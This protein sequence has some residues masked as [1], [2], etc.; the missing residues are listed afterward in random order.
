MTWTGTKMKRA[1]LLWN[2]LGSSVA[3]AEMLSQEWD[4]LITPDALRR[5]LSRK[6][7]TEVAPFEQSAE[8]KKQRIRP[9]QRDP[10][11]QLLFLAG[12]VH[13]PEHSRA[14]WGAIHQWLEDEQPDE[15]HLVGDVGEYSS[16][17]RHGGNW[18]LMFEDEC[19]QV[20][21]FINDLKKICPEAT[22]LYYEGNHETRY[23]RFIDENA[24]ALSGTHSIPK[25]CKLEE[26]GVEWVPENKQPVRRGD[27]KI[28]HGHQESRHGGELPK[29][30]AMKMAEVYG[31][32]GASVVYFHTHKS[33]KFSAP[34]HGG[35]AE[36]LAIGC[37][38]NLSPK[39]MHGKE[40]GW[41]HQFCAAYVSPN[42]HVDTYPVTITNGSFV[43]KGKRYSSKG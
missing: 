43:W 40:G 38:R 2:R 15:I 42:G 32:I 14:V 18:G 31:E 27:L 37:T 34:R 10:D 30:H 7:K 8:Q 1:R 24:P 35:V 23:Q 13:V 11:V 36:A 12:D 21:Y 33:Q 28:L 19:S 22:F 9:G 41:V 39:W 26:M 29:H 25:G 20:R 17:S 16:V 5:A 4:E 3:A 6:R